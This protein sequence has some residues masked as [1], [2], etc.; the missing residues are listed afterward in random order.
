[1]LRLSDAQALKLLRVPHG[2]MCNDARDVVYSSTTGS[3]MLYY[4]YKYMYLVLA[5]FL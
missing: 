5:L 1:M 4:E 3:S 2:L